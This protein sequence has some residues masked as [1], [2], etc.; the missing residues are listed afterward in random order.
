MSHR[1][2]RV[3][4]TLGVV[5]VIFWTLLGL[6]E[7]AHSNTY[8]TVGITAELQYSRLD[9]RAKRMGRV[10]GDLRAREDLQFSRLELGGRE[11][12]IDLQYLRVGRQSLRAS[13]RFEMSGSSLRELLHSLNR[14][15]LRKSSL[16]EAVSEFIG[17][18]EQLGSF[19]GNHSVQFQSLP[20]LDFDQPDRTIH[21]VEF[22]DDSS[23]EVLVLTLDF[24]NRAKTD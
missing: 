4:I 12:P 11:Y 19:S 2:R 5:G 23:S 7:P 15:I 22:L 9:Q 24:S 14:S 8:S 10:R 17:R 21:R 20:Q 1:G 13:G 6:S 3:D 18:Q 16:R